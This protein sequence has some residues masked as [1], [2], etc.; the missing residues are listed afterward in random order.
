[1]KSKPDNSPLD[2]FAEYLISFDE[3][4]AQGSTDLP[5]E[6]T[7][8]NDRAAR[9]LKCL[10]LLD[11]ARRQRPILAGEV[12]EGDTKQIGRF[13]LLRQLGRGGFGLVFL[14]MDEEL[15]RL[16]A[17]KIPRPERLLS[18]SLRERFVREAKVVAALSHPNLIP[19]FEAGTSG[20]ICYLASAFC[21]GPALSSWIELRG[22]PAEPKHAAQLVKKL[23]E[24]MQH[25][26]D[27]GVV[28][29][30]LKPSNI[31]LDP[32][33]PELDATAS[34]DA[35]EPRIVDF[36]LAKLTDS[37]TDATRDG[38]VLGTPSY[39]APE[40]A[41][42]ETAKIGPATDT[43]GLGAVLYE[44]LTG[45]TAFSADNDLEILQR[46]ANAP[47]PLPRSLNREIP[48]DLESICLKCLE[49][50]PHRRYPTCSALAD[51][52]HRFLS[53][54]PV[55]ARRPGP[56][57]R[58]LRW[59]RRNPAVAAL[60]TLL[61]IAM[62]GGLI[63]SLVTAASLNRSNSSLQI[64]NQRQEQ[65]L[66]EAKRSLGYAHQAIRELTRVGLQLRTPHAATDSVNA[67]EQAV[68]FYKGLVAATP[69]NEE[70]KAD[71]GRCQT[72]L[73]R[74]VARQGDEQR[75]LQLA[76][77]AVLLFEELPQGKVVF[78]LELARAW[79][80][81]AT[82]LMSLGKPDAGRRA[83]RQALDFASRPLENESKRQA[84]W[85]IGP[86]RLGLADALKSTKGGAEQRQTL[87]DDNRRELQQQL[88]LSASDYR[89]RG[90]LSSTLRQQ[91]MLCYRNGK[92]SQAVD[93]L[94]EAVSVQLPATE[95][96][97]WPSDWYLLN[98]IYRD[99]AG[100]LVRTKKRE[101]GIDILR[102]RVGINE[103]LVLQFPTVVT[104]RESLASACNALGANYLRWRPIDVDAAETWLN[105]AL[106]H[107]QELLRQHSGLTDYQDAV[108][109]T[110]NNLSVVAKE[111]GDGKAAESL[112]RRVL[113][114][115]RLI[116]A[117]D[118]EHR[119]ARVDLARCLQNLAVTMLK[120]RRWAES[121]E[122]Y[123]EAIGISRELL[124]ELPRNPDIR[125][126]YRAQNV[127]LTQVLNEQGQYIEAVEQIDD[128]FQL[129]ADW[130]PN[131]VHAATR[132]FEA[133]QMARAGS[134]QLK[135]SRVYFERGRRLLREVF[136][137]IPRKSSS[138]LRELVSWMLICVAE[139]GR[140]LELAQQA[141]ASIPSTPQMQARKQRLSGALQVARK[142]WKKSIELLEE[143]IQI[144][145]DRQ[146]TAYAM[147]AIAHAESGDIAAATRLL[148]QTREMAPRGNLLE[149]QFLAHFQS[150]AAALCHP[151]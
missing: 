145:D 38:A 26:H 3:A 36:G 49:K 17:L 103:K 142:D 28:H 110:L 99:F 125:K 138:S 9:A 150:R 132:L 115:R 119:S 108:A 93:L 83:F 106:E 144:Q 81:Q 118:P 63:A 70:L 111:R 140:D 12:L 33:E 31:L 39:M 66:Q 123:R 75:A 85:T 117:H 133:G 25:A 13:R 151:E 65:S 113:Q 122:A 51:D 20:V 5:Q 98:V 55:R 69:H 2:E 67:L 41:R 104:Y 8:D 129:D 48:R 100:V 1:M 6:T 32:I 124:A 84:L 86:I 14:A 91:A 146:A 121:E 47:A 59:C 79:E 137:Q 4:V 42:G 45:K 148:K 11:Q 94:K 62:V 120:G 135:G 56:S 109:D 82:C 50:E 61:L 116:A 43:Y 29:R 53:R 90:I 147:L 136:E 35:Y 89:V 130:W 54:L 10:S 15:D 21:D 58:L 34:L 30:D 40:Q 52:L 64:S 134:S 19:V 101:A 74:L 143:V 23:A 72:A 7:H 16:V 88:K 128:A 87:L 96:R 114:M 60:S 18:K 107:R 92:L 126:L 77:K 46:V 139:E 127:G 78:A 73:S 131:H 112:V 27:R 22:R 57:E 149:R 44:L 95:Q 71:L 141:I 105:K 68:Q 37:A 24:A 80:M 76:E 102:K 97:G